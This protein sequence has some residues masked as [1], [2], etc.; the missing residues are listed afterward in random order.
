MA[1]TPA[2]G[3]AL[4]LVV[5]SLTLAVPAADASPAGPVTNSEFELPPVTR[6]VETTLEGSAL[7][8]CYGIGH[9]VLWGS[10]TPQHQATGGPFGEPDPGQADPVGAAFSVL[11]D[12]QGTA[13]RQTSCVWNEEQGRDLAFVNPAGAAMSPVGWQYDL[14]NTPVAFGYGFDSDVM[15]RETLIRA[16]GSLSDRNLWQEIGP[17][18]HAFTPNADALELRVETG[19]I[20]DRAEIHLSLEPATPDSIA[21]DVVHECLLSFE[22]PQLQDALAASPGESLAVDPVEGDFDAREDTCDDLEAAW[23]DA[24]DDERRDVLAQTRLTEIALWYWNHGTEPVVVDGLR[25]RGA[26]LVAEEGAPASS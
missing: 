18:H 22:G 6:T 17:K 4:A 10:S 5:A 14:R 26:S 1:R 11:E 20:P 23:R 3:V 9:Q 24:S 8:A 25:L 13:D 15:D 21:N 19:S 2:L 12:P 7:D 16:D